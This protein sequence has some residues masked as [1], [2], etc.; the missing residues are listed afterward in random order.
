MESYKGGKLRKTEATTQLGC[1]IGISESN[2]PLSWS[3]GLEQ[4][5]KYFEQ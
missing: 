5:Q 1:E 3:Q 4:W 2:E